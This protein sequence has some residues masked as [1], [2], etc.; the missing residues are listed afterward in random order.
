MEVIVP[1]A[2]LSTRFPN[3]RPKYL[4]TAYDGEMMVQ[5]AVKNYINLYSINIVILKQHD[6]QFDVS[7]KLN[8]V[9][10]FNDNVNII[11]LDE[12]TSG[13]ADTVYQAIKKGNLNSEE[14]LLVK[15]C[16]SFFDSAEIL[17]NAI[18]VSKLS[19]NPNLRNVS[20]KSYVIS[21]NQNIVSSII[22]KKIVSDHFCVG[23][24]QFESVKKYIE[25]FDNLT[26]TQTNEIFVSDIIDYMLSNDEIFIHQEV[27]SFIDVGTLDDWKKFNDKP[28]YFC[29]IDGTI[30]KTKFGFYHEYEVIQ[31]NVD[32]LLQ[33]I[34]EGCKVIFCTARS[35]EHL[36]ITRKMLKTLGFI[37]Y[38]LVMDVNHSRR[39][40][41]NDYAASNPYPSAVA[42]NIERDSN[43]LKDIL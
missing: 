22:E 24:Y 12:P 2:G 42:V 11:V 27:E 14:R 41:I 3:V 5:K 32:A 40:L 16:D 9:F 28:T 23:G 13:P 15:D 19:E 43:K 34:E 29:D 30:V 1:C 38:Q 18:F 35:Y 7:K 31:E 21:N 20:A 25:A 17:G 33:K 26:S 39:V 10:K 4:L 8:D 36:E 37:D 6:I